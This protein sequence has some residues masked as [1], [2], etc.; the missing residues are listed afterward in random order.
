MRRLALALLPG[1]L[2]AALSA[3]EASP[4]TAKRFAKAVQ[5]L[6]SDDYQE[7]E[8]ASAEI[9]SLP[10]E[11]LRLIEAELKKAD[12]ELEVRSR[13]ERAIPAFKVKAKRNAAARL[14]EADAA[15]T[16]KTTVDAY[17]QVGRKDPKWDAKAVEALTIISRIWSNT[18]TAGQDRQAYNL[19]VAAA[20]AG[21]DDPLVLYAR[22]RL[23]DSVIR[24]SWP[25]AVQL[26]VDAA[27]AMKERGARYHEM[28]QGFCFARAADF[29]ARLKKDISDDD[30][31][32]VQEW[33]D[34]ALSRLGEGAADAEVPDDHL[35]E[36]GELMTGTWTKLTRD[37][38]IG[39]DKIFDALT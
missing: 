10:F 8:S 28:R 35:H 3:Q 25:E 4:D 39:F 1:L 9:A 21:C 31:K 7:R 34:L 13:L 23:Y 11:A 20:S 14:K 27:K 38:K 22:A 30:K 36:L 18:A 15:W 29:L 33:L 17:N 32:Q 6:G 26:H 2:S 12:L 37:R 16:R 19:S 24:K 5:K